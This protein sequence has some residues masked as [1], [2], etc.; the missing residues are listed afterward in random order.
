[1]RIK[2]NMA[3]ISPVTGLIFEETMFSGK[4]IISAKM[5]ELTK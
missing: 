1:M 2:D 4:K 3:I 5:R